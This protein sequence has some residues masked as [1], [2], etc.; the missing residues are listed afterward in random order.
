[1]IH[2]DHVIAHDIII[3]RDVER[4]C[5]RKIGVSRQMNA[6]DG[7]AGRNPHDKSVGGVFLLVGIKRH[8]LI[9]KLS[10]TV[11]NSISKTYQ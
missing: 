4:Y 10:V 6:R 8:S 9:N 2:L 11:F 1:M 5:I 7:G 3:V